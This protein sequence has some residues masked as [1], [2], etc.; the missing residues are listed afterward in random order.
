ME[1]TACKKD[2]AEAVKRSNACTGVTCV[3]LSFLTCN[4]GR[5]RA[6]LHQQGKVE[7]SQLCEDSR[8]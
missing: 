5:V 7:C 1:G 2:T 8:Q 6:P 4:M 3:G